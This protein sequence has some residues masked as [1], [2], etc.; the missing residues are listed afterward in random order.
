[1]HLLRNGIKHYDWGSVDAIPQFLGDRRDGNPVAEVWIGTHALSPSAV[2]CEDGREKPLSDVAGDLP[3]MVKL[4]AAERPLSLQVHPSLAQAEAGYAREEAEGIPLDAPH[5]VYK[6]P[7]HKPEMVYALTTFDSLI[8]FRPSAEI[9][10]VMGPLNTPLSNRIADELRAKTGFATIVRVIEMLLSE[11]VSPNE[12]HQIVGACRTLAS[13]GLDI[14]RAYQTAVEISEHYPD[15]VGVV[16]SLMLNRMTLQP[17]EAAYLETGVIHAHLKGL[18]IEVMAS[19]DNVLR[20]GLTTKHIDTAG[21]VAC[22]ES[23]MARVARVTPDFLEYDTEVFSPAG[24]GFAL[25]VTQISPAV[26]E[27]VALVRSEGSVLVCTGGEVTVTTDAGEKIALGR[28]ESLY[29]S[30]E[31]SGVAVHG[32]GEVAQ[33]YVPS[34]ADLTSR[35]V[36]AVPT[37]RDPSLPHE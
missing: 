19:S 6:D 34:S 10:R 5:R 3:F 27:G 37:W 2:V 24:G 29:L 23:G 13:L 20:A 17:G 15:D 30:P 36:E 32:L 12:V 35:L 18:C 22:L 9:L 28:G 16:I 4:L 26:A 8:G 31:D 14:K 25:A 1:M 11:D 33:A 21:L 7:N